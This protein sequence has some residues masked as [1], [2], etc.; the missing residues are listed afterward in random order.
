[1]STHPRKD[2]KRKRAPFINGPSRIIRQALSQDPTSCAST[3]YSQPHIST[4]LPS[5]D[6][7]SNPLTTLLLSLPLAKKIHDLILT[8]REIEGICRG[9]FTDPAEGMERNL[10][11]RM[12]RLEERYERLRTEVEYELERAWVSAGYL[13]ATISSFSS[14]GNPA[15]PP[16]PIPASGVL[17]Y[18]V[19][20]PPQAQVHYLDQEYSIDKEMRMKKEQIK[21][22]GRVAKRVKRD[23]G[24]E[25]VGVIE[26]EE[27]FE[28]A[29]PIEH[30]ALVPLSGRER[31]RMREFRFDV[32][33]G[34]KAGK[35]REDMMK[36]ISPGGSM[37]V[38]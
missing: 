24:C 18:A 14:L 21:R 36:C 19:S 31:K 29:Q 2:L 26:E 1:M 34:R 27:K 5:A 10:Q 8:S 9:Q 17:S 38:F 16:Q 25:E 11:Q 30:A 28:M 22:R 7:V 33:K 13:P 35:K 4:C 37:V 20:A 12:Q 15:P 6:T 23:G 32:G 3:H